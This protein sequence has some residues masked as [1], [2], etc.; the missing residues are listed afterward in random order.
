MD[1]SSTLKYKG[2]I[3]P[4]KH[5]F[6]FSVKKIGEK[7]IELQFPTGLEYNY[8]LGFLSGQEIPSGTI[9]FEHV[10]IDTDSSDGRTVS[11]NPNEKLEYTFYI[12]NIPPGKYSINI[13][14]AV[15]YNY[16]KMEFTISG[17]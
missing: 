13:G 1:L 10:D 16:V 5:E 15:S 2:E 12:L 8:S 4:E 14:S 9:C 7:E 6:I 11:L 17:E 3:D